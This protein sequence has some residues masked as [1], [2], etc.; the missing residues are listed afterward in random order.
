MFANMKTLCQSIIF[1][2]SHL[3]YSC[4]VQINWKLKIFVCGCKEGRGVEG[5][6]VS[7]RWEGGCYPDVQTRAHSLGTSIHRQGFEKDLPQA[8]HWI[9][10]K[11]KKPLS[12]FHKHNWRVGGRKSDA[13][14]IGAGVWSVGV[15]ASLAETLK[16]EGGLQQQ[17]GG[18]RTKLGSRR[19]RDAE[20]EEQGRFSSCNA[21]STLL[22]SSLVDQQ[23][24]LVHVGWVCKGKS[25]FRD[26]FWSWSC[27]GGWIKLLQLG[28]ELSLRWTLI[29]HLCSISF[30]H[31]NF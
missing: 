10:Q 4:I 17:L 21:S 1:V 29:G 26:W 30:S 5:C 11:K 22:E 19:R 16:L 15:G 8:E 2:L 7:G 13:P 31:L 25:C 14:I 28:G 23:L 24:S 18:S 6:S 20:T 3:T 12:D 27:G 9:D